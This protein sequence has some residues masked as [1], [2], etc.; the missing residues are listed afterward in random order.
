MLL[1]L[2]S[3]GVDHMMVQRVLSVKDLR[4]GQKAMIGSGIFVLIQFTIFLFAG[5]LIFYLFEGAV[6]NKDREFS[7]FIV[8]YLPVGLK[9]F[10]L[11]GIL[12]AAMSTLSSSINALASSTLIDLFKG[13]PSLLS[14]RLLSLFWAIILIGIALIFDESD[15][16]IVIIGLQIAS[17]TYGGLLGLFILSKFNK[18]FNSISLIIGLVCSFLI[19][20]YLKYLGI[21]WTWFILISVIVNITITI[22]VEKLVTRSGENS[23]HI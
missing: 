21:A 12:S 18:E 1:S 6:I 4:S 10:L 16:A 5:S 15:S 19:V 8:E 23:L 7:T 13:E 3:H 22:I 20:F 2:S 17:F 11:A 14:S 9:G